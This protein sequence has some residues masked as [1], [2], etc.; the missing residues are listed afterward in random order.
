M[1]Q[2]TTHRTLL[3][4]PLSYLGMDMDQLHMPFFSSAK[5]RWLEVGVLGPGRV[6]GCYYSVPPA[7]LMPGVCLPMALPPGYTITPVSLASLRVRN[8]FHSRLFQLF[9]FGAPGFHKPRKENKRGS[10][11]PD[12]PALLYVRPGRPV[13]RVTGSCQ[14]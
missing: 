1:L 11:R 3:P 5:Y 10:R 12:C 8:G 9:Q 4:Q 13:L 7:Q 2:L 14:Y 6:R